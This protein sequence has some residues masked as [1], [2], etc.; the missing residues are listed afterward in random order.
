MTTYIDKILNEL[1]YR[2][3]NGTPNFTNEQH[4]IK[5]S[6]VLKELDWPIEG[7]V[8]LIKTLTED[9][10]TGKGKRTTNPSPP[11]KYKY[12]YGKGGSTGGTEDGKDKKDKK[13]KQD[14]PPRRI[15]KNKNPLDFENDSIEDLARKTSKS[16]Y[17]KTTTKEAAQQTQD[18]RAD[19]FGGKTGKGGGD[20]TVQEEMGNMAKEIGFKNP[21]MTDQEVEDAIMKEIQEKYPDSKWAKDE[22]K[23]RELIKKSTGGIKTAKIIMDPDSG[24]DYKEKQP[25]GLP[26]T[27][28][29][30]DIVR[31]AILT[32]LEEAENEK[33]PNPDKIKHYQEELE[34]FQK[35]AGDKSITGTEGD[36]D[37]MVMYEDNNGNIRVA[38]VTNK[39]SEGDMISN[40]TISTVTMATEASAVEG[41][42]ID[43]VTRIQRAAMETGNGFNT[44]YVKKSQEVI[45]KNRKDL[46]EAGDIIGKASMASGGRSEF[47]NKPPSVKYLKD[48]LK[49]KTVQENLRKAGID[50]DKA[51]KNPQKYANEIMQA[52][53]DAHGTGVEG[54]GTG[55]QGVAYSTVKATKVTRSIRKKVKSCMGGDKS[56][57]KECCKK[58][59]KSTSGK[60]GKEKKLFGGVFGAD[61]IERIMNNKGLE[62]LE[63]EQVTRQRSMDDMHEQSVNRLREVDLQYYMDEEGLTEE[64][65]IEKMRTEPGPNEKSYTAGFL[66]RTH[67][68]DYIMGTVDGRVL[69]EMGPN[70]HSP[71]RIRKALAELLGY[72]GDTENPEEFM[73][74]VLK[75]VRADHENQ[76]LTFID[77]QGNNI[78]IGIDDHRLAGRKEKM[79]GHF[80]K[81]LQKKLKELAEKEDK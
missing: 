1:S 23:S 73:D 57:L 35:K 17:K 42:D 2:V 46:K 78:E 67:L 14:I 56:K 32:K 13:E 29:E 49:N 63:D 10:Y 80:G 68:H 36:A 66:H 71:K 5:L 22:K 30:G 55:G 54:I 24:F 48:N 60:K 53:M 31:N 70:S 69:G 8:E 45:K 81:D 65:A 64:E 18:N 74:Y 43:A 72:E 52:S 76:T 33:P 6:D 28:T 34:W 16:P 15:Y 51:K 26:A 47:H 59:S 19:V 77:A 40:S 4:L 79:A 20:T 7:R 50:P 11:P 3:S 75:N 21:N 39:Q 9:T 25:E 62:Q 41:A 38:Y 44:R 58:V 27:T 37:T 12:T 61:E